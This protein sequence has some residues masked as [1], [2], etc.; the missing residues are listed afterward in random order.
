MSISGCVGFVLQFAP[1]VIQVVDLSA[2]G[3][4]VSGVLFSRRHFPLVLTVFVVVEAGK[5]D[6]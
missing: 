1:A 6:T 3:Q 5:D 4:T 2:A